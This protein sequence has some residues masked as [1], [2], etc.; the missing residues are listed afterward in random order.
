MNQAG[1][2][3]VAANPKAQ[4]PPMGAKKTGHRLQPHFRKM[5]L[6]PGGGWSSKLSPPSCNTAVTS[7]S[8][9]LAS[10]WPVMRVWME[11]QE[12]Q[13]PWAPWGQPAF[14]CLQPWGPAPRR[15]SGP[16]WQ[17]G[18][19]GWGRTAILVLPVARTPPSAAPPAPL[20]GRERGCP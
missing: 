1:W 13:D 7:H 14:V 3:G 6:G 10:Q 16:S 4:A 8:F 5:P 18:G 12:A 15:P 9:K 17:R 2:A 11:A 20:S 19:A